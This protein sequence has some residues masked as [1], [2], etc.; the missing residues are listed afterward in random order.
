M[1]PAVSCGSGAG[2][3]GAGTVSA[4]VGVAPG[5]GPVV[6]PSRDGVAPPPGV[7]PP[8]LPPPPASPFFYDY[9]QQPLITLP[10]D[11]FDPAQAAIDGDLAVRHPAHNVG[12]IYPAALAETLLRTGDSFGDHWIKCQARYAS[13]NLVTD[14]YDGRDGVPAPC[15]L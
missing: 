10:G 1:L 5:A 9:N 11:R 13:Y 15:K 14:T 3:L 8:A 2:G 12:P 7:A 6:L 4:E